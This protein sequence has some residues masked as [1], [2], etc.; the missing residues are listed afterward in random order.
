MNT[1]RAALAAKSPRDFALGIIEQARRYFEADGE[2][3]PVSFVVTSDDVF[4]CPLVGCDKEA[5]RTLQ[6]K[7]IDR[8]AAVAHVHVTEA[9]V[10][11]E[12]PTAPYEDFS[13]PFAEHPRR[14]EIIHVALETREGETCLWEIPILRDADGRATL[15]ETRELDETVSGRMTGYFPATRRAEVSA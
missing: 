4:V 3:L 11:R 8:L 9:W 10:I 13:A 12:D 7:A 2:L 14:R 6:Q 15:G 5:L 1:T